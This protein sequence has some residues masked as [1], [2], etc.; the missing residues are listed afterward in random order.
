[1]LAIY[2]LGYLRLSDTNSIE[3]L[4]ENIDFQ[5][6]KLDPKLRFQRWSEYPARDAL[7]RIG[8]PVV[9]LILHRLETEASEPRRRLIYSVLCSQQVLGRA[10]A[11]DQLKERSSAG[12][13]SGSRANLE[14]ALKE[15]EQ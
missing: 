14:L 9:N 13:D 12:S 11:L 1:M 6:L 4:I 15:L 3:Y 7:T 8:K 2:L 10:A 5:A